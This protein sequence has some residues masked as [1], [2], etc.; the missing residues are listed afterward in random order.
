MDTER[1]QSAA[2]ETAKR[3]R[4]G[5]RP[6]RNEHDVYA[7]ERLRV[8]RRLAGVTQH[9]LGQL[10]GISFQAV[11]K[12]ENGEN[13]LSAGRLVKAAELLG[14]TLAFFAKETPRAEPL[15]LPTE[16][17]SDEIALLRAY[18]ALKS[19]RLRAQLLRL[20]ETMAEADDG[21][22]SSRFG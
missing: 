13:R 5:R 18:R 19:E 16:L 3:K 4:G 15:A 20:L 8:A 1:K 17:S 6:R 22:A 10:L 7:G 21:V 12:Y 9:R 11:Q 14:V 2:I